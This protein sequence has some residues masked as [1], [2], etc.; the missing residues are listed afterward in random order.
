MGLEVI[1][2]RPSPEEHRRQAHETVPDQETVI[3]G[4]V[5]MMKTPLDLAG[6]L[7]HHQQLGVQ[8]F[9]LQL[10]D[11]SREDVT[12][13]ADWSG[14]VECT[15][16]NGTQRDYSEQVHRQSEHL[17]SAIPRAIAAGITHLLHIDD[18]ELLYCAGGFDE[19]RAELAN[20]PASVR[21]HHLQ[22]LEVLV[23]PDGLRAEES[24][25]EPTDVGRTEAE[26]VSSRT[27]GGI[28]SRGGVF[29]FRHDKTEFACYVN[30]KALG[31]VAAPGLRCVGP[32]GFDHDGDGGG[33]CIH[34]EA[35]C[36]PRRRLRHEI[37]PWTAVVLHFESV[38]LAGW[39]RKFSDLAAT[40]AEDA[41]AIGRM[42]GY[43]RESVLAMIGLR[44]A[45]EE[46]DE[47]ALTW[48]MLKAAAIWRMWRQAPPGALAD[49]EAV[50]AR[51]SATGEP[52]VLDE[53]G[54]TLIRI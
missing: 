37:P 41:D 18:D 43:Y 17:A 2:K 32:H 15:F 9:F 5:S 20:A 14:V 12:L 28:F 7:Y 44:K 40:H 48:A 34:G 45:R 24:T 39:R 23:A 29:A 50:L 54:V 4:I 31:R 51:L 53:L 3:I 46:K 16:A 26:F 10:E 22:N 11:A 42:P 27:E 1:L 30:G 21:D 19:L 13:L 36:N 8:R 47:L 25:D 49:N 33:D 6:W 38:T 52:Q 35:S